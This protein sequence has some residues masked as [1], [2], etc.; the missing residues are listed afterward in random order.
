MLDE[1]AKRLHATPFEPFTILTTDGNKYRVP[2]PDHAL[3]SPRGTRVAVFD[4]NDT[5]A[6]LTALHIV[7][8]KSGRN[9]HAKSRR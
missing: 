4:D 7:A 3:I 2:H 6:M 9:G 1:I 8:V 5:S